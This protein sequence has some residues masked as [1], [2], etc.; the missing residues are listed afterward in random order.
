MTTL[1][2]RITI[3]QRAAGDDALGQPN[4]AWADFDTVWA[5]VRW[6]TGVSVARERIMAG[7]EASTSVCSVMLRKRSDI[8]A[9]MRLVHDGMT[10]DITAIMPS[11]EGRD[12]MFLA[13]QWVR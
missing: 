6:P 5:D 3:Q 8:H 7:V 11:N 1:N 10:L 9:G 2:H 13:C 12:M 4:G